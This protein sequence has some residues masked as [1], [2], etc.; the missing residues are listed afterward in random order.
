MFM[1]VVVMDVET[2]VKMP[3]HWRIADGS[4]I[5]YGQNN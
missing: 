4:T 5:H 1:M 3:V 2:E